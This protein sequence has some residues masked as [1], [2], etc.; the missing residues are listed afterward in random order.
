MDLSG[1]AALVTGAG[2][3]LG[4][5]FAEG[6]IGRGAS[7][8]V[9]YCKSAEG[10]K[11]VV[12]FAQ[13]RG[14]RAAAIQADLCDLREAVSLLERAEREL[15]EEIDW[16]VN[17]ASIFEPAGPL[18][19]KLDRWQR[20]LDVNLTAPFLL[21]QSFARAR[22][23][24]GGAIVNIL[25]WRARRPDPDA[26]A[27]TISKAGLDAMTRALAREFA[28]GIRVNG[29]ALGPILPPPGASEVKEVHRVPLGRA[30]R[31]EECVEAL[32]FLLKGA[33]YVT[34]DVLHV[35]GGRNLS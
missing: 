23:E 28:P 31:V 26:F 19:T 4:R 10:A 25:D 14:A 11:A 32:C 5:A 6:L 24:R 17:N 13:K 18:E 27:Y 1:H 15:G 12:A 16:L 30:G 2:R 9:H 22:A 20:H 34:G 35:D 7:V 33:T 3:R 29:L 8:A 21:S